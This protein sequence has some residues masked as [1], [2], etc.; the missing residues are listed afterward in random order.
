LTTQTQDASNPPVP[1]TQVGAL[2]YN[3]NDIVV[4]IGSPSAIGFY[5]PAQL[6]STSPPPPAQAPITNGIGGPVSFAFDSANNLYVA[7][8]FANSV[9]RYVAQ[10]G[11]P[12]TY[13]TTASA[14]TPMLP[15]GM[16][17]ALQTPQG[18]AVDASGNVYI[19]NSANNFIYVYNSSGAY[20]Y[21]VGVTASLG[22]SSPVA[23]GG[24]SALT[25]SVSGLPAGGR[26]RITDRFPD[27][28]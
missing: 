28:R 2:A 22:A 17:P 24:T 7:N 5:T 3:G 25:W 8:Y 12:P 1:F 19:A 6:S 23:L 13:S 18:V 27:C 4:G 15:S 14:F 20:E 11:T 16:S 10:T 21:T 26:G 9:T